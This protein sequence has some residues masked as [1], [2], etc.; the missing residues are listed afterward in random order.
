VFTGKTAIYYGNESYFDDH[1][2]HVLMPNTPLS[3]CDKTANQLAEL[4]RND[5]YISPSTFFYDGGGCC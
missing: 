1:K 3:I 2:G 4:E 5:I